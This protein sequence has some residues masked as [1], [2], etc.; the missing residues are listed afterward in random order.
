[1]DDYRGERIVSFYILR[2]EYAID[3][4]RTSSWY[5]LEGVSAEW[6]AL[7]NIPELVYSEW[8]AKWDILEYLSAT[9]TASWSIGYY[10]AREFTA[11]WNVA[12]D[13]GS[14][15]KHSFVLSKITNRFLKNYR[16]R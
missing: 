15:A 6:I 2:D 11:L 1:M 8:I 4:E 12:M 13:F 14:K 16:G 7:W 3:R 5:I 9:W 10:I